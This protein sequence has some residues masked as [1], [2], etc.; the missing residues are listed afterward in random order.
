M[1]A[2]K[3]Q[4]PLELAIF[5]NDK[6]PEAAVEF[7]SALDHDQTNDYSL[8]LRGITFMDMGKLEEAVIDNIIY[9]V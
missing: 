4:V 2:G 3:V 1:D 7:S 8:F 5:K 6:F 9:F